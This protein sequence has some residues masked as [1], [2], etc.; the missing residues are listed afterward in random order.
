MKPFFSNHKWNLFVTASLNCQLCRLIIQSYWLPI[1]VSEISF[2]KSEF[3]LQIHMISGEIPH[4]FFA[5]KTWS[6]LPPGFLSEVGHELAMQYN[7]RSPLE[8]MSG[9]LENMVH[10]E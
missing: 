1:E 4:V 2:K 5:A 6:Q 3:V 8:N 7:D 10:G 9:D